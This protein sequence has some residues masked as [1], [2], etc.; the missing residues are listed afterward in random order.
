MIDSGTGST[1]LAKGIIA[2]EV[3]HALGFYHMQ[4]TFDRDQYVYINTTNITP[5]YESQFSVQ[6]Q[7]TRNGT[8]YDFSSVM[9]YGM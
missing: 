5:G 2:H 1:C 3:L 7:T 4:A 9:H 8:A 6:S